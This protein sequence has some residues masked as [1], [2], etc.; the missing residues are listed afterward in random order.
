MITRLSTDNQSAPAQ[1]SIGPRQVKTPLTKNRCPLTRDCV[2]KVARETL[3]WDRPFTTVRTGS[4]EKGDIT[5]FSEG[6]LN[7]SYN[8]V[9][10]W[11]FKN[12]DKVSLLHQFHHVFTS[13]L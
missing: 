8:C 13:D 2:L 12:P 9:D 6:A 1:M 5:W 3:H 4:F 7:A 10:R 11:A